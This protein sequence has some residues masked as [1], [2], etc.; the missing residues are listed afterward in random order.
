MHLFKWESYIPR[1]HVKV[2]CWYPT[3]FPHS[4]K[5]RLP[6]MW[7][8]E[9]FD[10]VYTVFKK[11]VNYGNDD[12]VHRW[13]ERLTVHTSIWSWS[14]FSFTCQSVVL[15]NKAVG[16]YTKQRQERN[17]EEPITKLFE[18]YSTRE[19]SEKYTNRSYPLFVRNAC[20]SE[21]RNDAHWTHVL[22]GKAKDRQEGANLQRIC[23][24]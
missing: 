6:W 5:E 17:K 11:I 8:S 3:L 1:Y 18:A 19:V 15:G 20:S 22:Y 16:R 2:W 10:N 14:S 23:S 4:S 21:V 7:R 12:T 9:G 13:K 24:S